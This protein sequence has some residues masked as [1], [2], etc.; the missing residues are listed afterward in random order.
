MSVEQVDGIEWCA[1][2]AAVFDGT[3]H[4]EL[5]QTG[6]YN[7]GKYHQLQICCTAVVMHA[8]P[9]IMIPSS[10]CDVII[11]AKLFNVATGFIC[12]LVPLSFNGRHRGAGRD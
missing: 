11:A 5:G 2:C 9:C 10:Y 8:G 7:F 1:G 3:T 4:T 6:G 12:S